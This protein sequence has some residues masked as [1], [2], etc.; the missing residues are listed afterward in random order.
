M[1]DI[2]FKALNRRAFLF[3]SAS[4]LLSLAAPT[5]LRAQEAAPARRNI[6]SFRLHD[7]QDHFDSLGKGILLSDTTT[8]VLQHWTADGKCAYTPHPFL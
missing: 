1:G 2:T 4:E 5:V 7:W 6:S 8:R 3:A